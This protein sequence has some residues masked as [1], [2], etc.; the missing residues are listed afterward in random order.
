MTGVNP[1][2]G[3]EVSNTERAILLG[4]LFL[5]AAL[6]GTVKVV[7]KAADAIKILSKKSPEIANKFDGIEAALDGA[8]EAL[9]KFS[10]LSKDTAKRGEITDDVLRRFTS[11]RKKM[12]GEL[13]LMG[14]KVVALA[15][16]KPGEYY[17]G[18]E[19]VWAK[20]QFRANLKKL[21]DPNMASNIDAHHW[22]PRELI[23]E[24]KDAGVWINDPRVM[25]G[26]EKSI[27]EDLHKNKNYNKIWRDFFDVNP[28]ATYDDVMSKLDII[29][30]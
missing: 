6:S 7:S 20:T 25:V 22:L 24:F 5:P 9:D 10:T 26:L 1:I 18:V 27:H 3:E 4:S 17:E 21:V 8:D 23:G 12:D 15:N 19:K 13:P 28:N 30:G 29:R 14:K 11:A 2:T 16:K